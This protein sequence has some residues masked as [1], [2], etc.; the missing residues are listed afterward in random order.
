MNTARTVLVTGASGF[1]GRHLCAALQARGD[2]VIALRR[3][4]ALPAAEPIDAVINLAGAPILGPPWTAGRRRLLRDSRIG[5]T[6]RLVAALAE[7]SQRPAVLVSASAVGYYGVRDDQPVDESTAPQDIFQS[8]L[9]AD[10]EQ[11][12]S[13]AEALGIRVVRLRLGVVLGRDGGAL[14]Q[15]ALPARLGLGAVMGDG[16]QG[17]PWIHIDDVVQLFLRTLDDATLGGAMNAVAPETATQRQFQQALAQVL[18]RPLWLRVP[19]APVR[20]ALGEMAQLL[21]DGQHVLPR[22]ALAAGFSFRFPTLAGAL[23]DLYGEAR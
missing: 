3:G 15:L 23:A 7:R 17:M 18:R 22:A 13:A 10:W 16:R 11:A 2:R 19:A 5:T 21:V 1:I 8:Q 14:P 6:Q 20:W 12:A 9:C 4:G